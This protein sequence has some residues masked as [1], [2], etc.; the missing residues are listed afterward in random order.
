MQHRNQGVHWSRMAGFVALG[1]WATSLPC[2]AAN[3][4]TSKPFQGVKA[5]TGTVSHSQQGSQEILTLSDDFK[6]PDA[7]AP[8]W[9]IVDSLGNVYLLDSLKLK[10]DRI[11]RQITVPTYIHDI[12]KVQ[13]WCAWAETLLGETTFDTTV[14]LL[15]NNASESV[16]AK[17]THTSKP[18]QGVKANTGTV[19]H[20]KRGGQNV[21]TLSNDFKIPDAPAPHWQI[22]DSKGK[23]YLLQRLVIKGDKFHKTIT[24]PAYVPDIAKV[25]IWCAWAQVLLGETSF[26]HTIR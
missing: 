9:Q 20:F 21:L 17:D 16:S 11:S 8:H 3:E 25:Q 26:A 13:I 14:S 22:V 4:H 19:S 6:V 2:F 12:A 1:L 15:G 7:P 10:G 23:I 18:F 24:V 5:N